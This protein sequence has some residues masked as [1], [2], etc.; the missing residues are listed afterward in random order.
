MELLKFQR[1]LKVALLLMAS[2]IYLG[3]IY[4]SVLDPVEI[5]R[6]RANIP[7]YSLIDAWRWCFVTVTTIGYGDMAPIT[8]GGRLFGI[9]FMIYGV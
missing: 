7:N 6:V 5:K 1:S 9:F 2:F 8:D 4:F 3:T